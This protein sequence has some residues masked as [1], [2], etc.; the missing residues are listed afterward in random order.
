MS[1]SVEIVGR[2]CLEIFL[3]NRDE[4]FLDVEENC[5]Y[6][7]VVFAVDFN[8]YDTG[9]SIRIVSLSTVVLVKSN[10]SSPRTAID[11]KGRKVIVKAGDMRFTIFKARQN[12]NTYFSYQ[13][14]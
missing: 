1:R 3:I 12:I 13:D 14:I 7:F 10:F 4:G 5:I 9:Q 8:G 11:N 2:V 6:F